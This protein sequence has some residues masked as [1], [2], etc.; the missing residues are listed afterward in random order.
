VHDHVIA[1]AGNLTSLGLVEAPLLDEADI[2]Q[3]GTEAL[4]REEATLPTSFPLDGGLFEQLAGSLVSM[5]R[6]GLRSLFMAAFDQPTGKLADQQIRMVAKQA[7]L[8]FAGEVY[9]PGAATN[10]TSYV[11]G[12]IQSRADVVVPAMPGPSTVGFLVTCNQLHARF[13][14]AYPGGELQPRQIQQLGGARGVLNEAIEFDAMP[15][16][17]ATDRFPALRTFKADLDAEY[18]A[19]DKGA[20]PDLRTPGSLAVWLS[21]QII[22][23]IAGQVGALDARAFLRALRD[24]PSVDTLGLTPPWSPGKTGPPMSPRTTNPFGYFITQRSGEEVLVDPTPV[25]PYQALPPA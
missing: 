8:D 17:S 21:V 19:G 16:L 23:R 20:A 18:A 14:V 22:G 7:G 12:A 6:Q 10:F 11:Q 9:I 4:S 25:N 2:A 24:S 3:V 13:R 15:P 1:T 5:K